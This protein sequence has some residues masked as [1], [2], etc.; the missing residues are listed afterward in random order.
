M[1]PLNG[2]ALQN[3]FPFGSA[4]PMF[5]YSGYAFSISAMKALQEAASCVRSCGS[6]ANAVSTC[7]AASIWAAWLLVTI[8]MRRIASSLT[9]SIAVL[10]SSAC[11]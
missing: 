1:T 7:R 10:R 5:K 8:R 3:R 6:R 11:V 4:T 2:T 9:L